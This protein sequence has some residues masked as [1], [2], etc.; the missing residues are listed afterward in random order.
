V[1]A[2]KKLGGKEGEGDSGS[3]ESLRGGKSEE[4]EEK[5]WVSH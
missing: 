4:K 1:L 5:A 3:G 2:H